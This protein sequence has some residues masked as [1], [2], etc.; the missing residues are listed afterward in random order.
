MPE[1]LQIKARLMQR[2]NIEHNKL[3]PIG[4]DGARIDVEAE[5]V[6]FVWFKVKV[7]SIKCYTEIKTK[8]ENI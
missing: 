5:N 6:A 8:K 7:N 2:K 4:V 3:I 1:I